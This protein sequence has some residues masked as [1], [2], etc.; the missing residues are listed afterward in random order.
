MDIR[1]GDLVTIPL[2]GDIP[3]VLRERGEGE[4]W[5]LISEAYV[6]GIMDGKILTALTPVAFSIR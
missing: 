4:P 2:G 1:E 5:Q 3:F 6:R